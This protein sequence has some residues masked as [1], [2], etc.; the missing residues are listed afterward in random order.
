MLRDP[1]RALHAAKALQVDVAYPPP[2]ERAK[3]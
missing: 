2:C 1:R 3:D